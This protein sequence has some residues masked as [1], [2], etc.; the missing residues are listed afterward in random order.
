[1]D[2]RD[3]GDGL[4]MTVLQLAVCCSAPL[5]RKLAVMEYLLSE[6][7]PLEAVDYTESTALHTAAA[8]GE[9]QVVARLLKA[10]PPPTQ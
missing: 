6:K 5:D 9:A 10:G 1:M 2:W 4:G 7:V 3:E 8:L